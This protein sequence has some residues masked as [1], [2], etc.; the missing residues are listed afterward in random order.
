MK[1][2]KFLL[3]L[4]VQLAVF[5]IASAQQ[6]LNNGRSIDTPP[7]PPTSEKIQEATKDVYKGYDT[8][9]PGN[10][11]NAEDHEN[12]VVEDPSLDLDY[13]ASEAAH[14]STDKIMEKVAALEAELNT[15]RL[16]NNQLQLENRTIR[17]GMSQCCSQTGTDVTVAGSFLLQN[18]P[19]P[20]DQ[21]TKIQYFVPE[22]LQNAQLEIR[23]VKGEMIKSIQISDGGFGSIEIEA[24]SF[25]QG[26]YVYT[27]N[28]DG[29][30]IDSKV[31]ILT[32]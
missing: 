22:D 6:V 7:T 16:A 32:K 3:I 31:M 10:Y 4:F 15:L 21:S 30:L 14:I 20:F 17:N 2:I 23:N 5:Q 28:V 18:A 29:K 25:A 8:D 26:S 9:I 19:N 13:V 1:N 24:E 11:Q 27:L 12:S